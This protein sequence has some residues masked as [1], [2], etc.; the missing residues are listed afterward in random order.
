MVKFP[1][2]EKRI[3]K[4]IFICRRCKTK[5]RAPNLK[6]ISGKVTCRKCNYKALRVIRKK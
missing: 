6:V 4:N 5:T 2:A 1:E 3:I